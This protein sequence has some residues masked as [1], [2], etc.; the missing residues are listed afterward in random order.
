MNKKGDLPVTILVIGVFA[1]CG[2]ALLSF[3]N[4][5]IQIKK[6]FVGIDLMEEMNYKIEEGNF[7]GKPADDFYLEKNATKGFLWWSEDVVVFSVKYT[8]PS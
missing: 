7:L 6:S 4:S 1:I 2:L 3:F 8:S 5:T